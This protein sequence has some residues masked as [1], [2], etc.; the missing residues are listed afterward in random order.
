MLLR[1]A[2]AVEARREGGAKAANPALLLNEQRAVGEGA[3]EGEKAEVAAGAVA[4][5][6][7]N[8]GGM[9]HT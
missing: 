2:D 4:E 6:S 3:I 5:V 9:G 7:G 8:S 1:V